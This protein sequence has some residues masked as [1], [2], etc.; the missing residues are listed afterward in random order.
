MG[1]TTHGAAPGM[2]MIN[3]SPDTLLGKCHKMPPQVGRQ[4]GRLPPAG[5]TDQFTAWD[6]C[7]RHPGVHRVLLWD[8][9]SVLQNAAPWLSEQADPLLTQ[10]SQPQFSPSQ[11]VCSQTPSRAPLTQ[12]QPHS[13]CPMGKVFPFGVL[14]CR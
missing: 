9:I 8:G 13:P 14:L 5:G 12:P 2:E 3:L 11:D 1:R 10:L 6:R 7:C 4:A